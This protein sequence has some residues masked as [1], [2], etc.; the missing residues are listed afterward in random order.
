MRLFALS[1][2]GA[3]L[4]LLVL[5]A[6]V[7]REP[8]AWTPADSSTAESL[9]PP[10]ADIAKAHRRP[11]TL[12][13]RPLTATVALEQP[14]PYSTRWRMGVGLPDNSPLYYDW[15]SSPSRMVSKLECEPG[16]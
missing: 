2:A 3:A 13:L 12:M 6:L 4:A 9:V 14:A 1:V 10:S 7:V 11:D 16:V 15:A 5:L 8:P